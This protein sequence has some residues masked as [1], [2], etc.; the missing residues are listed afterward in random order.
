MSKEK[1]VS[2]KIKDDTYKRLL[3]VSKKES[4]T[5]SDLIDEMLDTHLSQKNRSDFTEDV[6]KQIFKLNKN[7]LEDIEINKSIYKLLKGY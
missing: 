6:E 3:A 4:I 5:I 7:V 2:S 1:Y